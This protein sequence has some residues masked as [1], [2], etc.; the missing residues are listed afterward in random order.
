MSRKGV[1]LSRAGDIAPCIIYL[2]RVAL[3][4]SLAINAPFLSSQSP[5]PRPP[6]RDSRRWF[7]K[8]PSPSSHVTKMAEFGYGFSK[9]SLSLYATK[10]GCNN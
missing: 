5:R 7:P 10:I 1:E 2:F 8:L 6:V 3:V 4:S 9:L